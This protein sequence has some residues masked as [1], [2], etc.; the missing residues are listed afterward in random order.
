MQPARQKFR[1]V[2]AIIMTLFPNYA[3]F[4]GKDGSIIIELYKML[5]GVK[6]A[7]YFLYLLMFDM[8]HA[9]GFV[10]SRVDPCVHLD[11]FSRSL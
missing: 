6:E 3:D 5:Y 9:S 7:G 1:E 4:Q 10:A 2:A 8:F 11:L